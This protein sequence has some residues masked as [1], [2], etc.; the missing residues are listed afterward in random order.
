MFRR[1]FVWVLGGMLGAL[2]LVLM[3]PQ[4]S[5]SQGLPP[6]VTLDVVKEFPASMVPG[7]KSIKQLLFTLQ[8]G[9]KL[10]NFAPPGVHYCTA[11]AGEARVVLG[12]KT[13]RYRTGDVWL[14]EKGVA[15]SV[16]ND[17]KVTFVDSFIEVIY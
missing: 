13:L 11:L 4:Q 12:N 6:G 5:W 7:A 10:E 15:F 2:L 3:M 9:A 17:G 16:Y 14:E 8:P 1:R